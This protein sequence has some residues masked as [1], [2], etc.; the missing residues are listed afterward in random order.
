MAD[1]GFIDSGSTYNHFNFEFDNTLDGPSAIALSVNL[2]E[3]CEQDY[4]TIASWFDGLTP[5]GAPFTVQIGPTRADRSGSNYGG[6]N[7]TIDLGATSDFSSA[8][9]VLVAE[10]IEI[11]MTAQNKGWAANKSNGEGL[12]QAASFFLYPQEATGL[13]GIK[14]WLFALPLFPLQR[15]P[16]FVTKTDQTDTN[17]FSYRCALLFIYY[18]QSQLGFNM[19]AIVQAASDTLE[20]VYNNLT[21]DHNGFSTFSA[22]LLARFPLDQAT[23]EQGS[24]NPFPYLPPLF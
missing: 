3:T 8:R 21:Q 12:S 10:L 14:A 6:K 2:L 9:S 1:A 4:D 11:F 7:I 24:E 22:L 20:G 13:D 18:L 5:G 19:R 23:G 17:K 16:D 15:R